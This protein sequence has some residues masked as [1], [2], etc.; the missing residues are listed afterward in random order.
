MPTVT[1][2]IDVPEFTDEEIRD[3]VLT[4]IVDEVIG[5]YID[6]DPELIEGRRGD[7]PDDFRPSRKRVDGGFIKRLREEARELVTQEVKRVVESRVTGVVDEVL[8]GE[9]QPVTKWGDKD[10]GPTTLRAMIGKFGTDYLNATVD[11]KGDSTSYD[12]RN[13]K[14]TRLHWLIAQMIPQVYNADI[15]GFVQQQA[16]EV[17]RA[18]SGRVSGEI[19]ETV[20]RILGL[21]VT[22]PSTGA[23]Q[24]NVSTIPNPPKS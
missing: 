15:K 5:S 3:A 23:L 20:Q 4:R 12:A 11:G 6:D 2:Q 22:L 9:F 13:S 7:D 16:D 17:K 18:F 14:T 24:A 1:I 8:A 19:T 21:P 10:G